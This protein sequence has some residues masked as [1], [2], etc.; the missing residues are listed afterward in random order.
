MVHDLIE[1]IL[2][3]GMFLEDNWT[4]ENLG[5]DRWIRAK[6]FKKKQRSLWQRIYNKKRNKT[7]ITFVFM[8][9]TC[10]CTHF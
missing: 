6:R 1:K 4:D 8:L 10:I 7:K 5:C 9:H 3:F 2:A